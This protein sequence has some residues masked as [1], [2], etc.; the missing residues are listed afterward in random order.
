MSQKDFLFDHHVI[1][2]L[3]PV[4]DAFAT[5]S[6]TGVSDAYSLSNYGKITFLIITGVATGGTAN[7]VVTLNCSTLATMAS[8]T[9]CTFKYRV[10]ASS[11]TVDTWGA[12][13]DATTSGFA[14]TAASNYMYLVE[15][16]A[17]DIEATS[18]GKKFVQ[19]TVTEN[20]D[21]PVVATIIAILSDPK[22]PQAVPV[23]AIA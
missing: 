18:A 2:G 15:V 4:A 5:T 10:C 7:G 23:Q 1:A 8:P 13:T 21:D 6:T 14:M 20:V 16:N 22:L 9:L 19:L 11:T 17:E 12:L 3:Y